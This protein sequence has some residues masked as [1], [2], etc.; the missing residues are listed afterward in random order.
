HRHE[1]V[2]L[3]DLAADLLVPRVTAGQIALVVPD[4]ETVPGQSV[5]EAQGGLAVLRGIAQKH[6]R[7]RMVRAGWGNSRHGDVRD[8]RLGRERS[9]LGRQE[10]TATCSL[11]WGRWARC[12]RAPQMTTGGWSC[13]QPPV[14]PAPRSAADACVV[15]LAVHPAAVAVLRALD[16]CLLARTD[17]PVGRSD[18]LAPIDVRLTPLE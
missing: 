15:L 10:S 8:S 16:A 7:C 13:D 9:K 4:L 1:E 17:V 2:A 11:P 6:G 12:D 18:G 5:A 3:A 14:V